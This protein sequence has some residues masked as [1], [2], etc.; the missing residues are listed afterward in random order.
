MRIAQMLIL[1]VPPVKILEVDELDQTGRGEG[2][3]RTHRSLETRRRKLLQQCCNARISS[4]RCLVLR[5]GRL[6][7]FLLFA[8]GEFSSDR[9]AKPR[10]LSVST[11]RRMSVARSG[12]SS[13]YWCYLAIGQGVF[14]LLFFSGVCL[15][16]TFYHAKLSDPWLRI[17]RSG[18]ALHR[19]CR[20]GA[21]FH[22]RLGFGVSRRT[23]RRDRHLNGRVSASPF[24][25]GRNALI[26]LTSILIGLLLAA[27]DL[28]LRAGLAA[29]AYT[30]VKDECAEDRNFPWF[31]RLPSYFHRDSVKPAKPAARNNPRRQEIDDDDDEDLK[32]PVLLKLD[33]SAGKSAQLDPFDATD[34]EDAKPAEKKPPRPRLRP[35]RGRI[36]SSSLPNMVKPRQTSPPSAAAE[37]TGRISSPAVGLPGRRRTRICREPG[38]IRPREGRDA[39]TGAEGIQH[40]RPRRRDR[41]R[42]GHHDVRIGPG[43]GHQGVGRSPRCPTTSCAP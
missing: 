1:P 3:F 32:P 23:R 26:L 15:A 22:A 40:R 20:F 19:V 8:A 14:P 39:R 34:E 2:G 12:R 13:A 6:W 5:D 41:H 38:K 7:F 4:G 43:A 31:P 16:M 33:K 37:G 29:Q 25:Y 42:A 27:D 28:V 17:A 30:T 9:L 18:D 11:D 24:Q 36:S 10:R 21:P 35:R